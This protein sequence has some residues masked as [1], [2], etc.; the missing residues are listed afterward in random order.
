MLA[1]EKGPPSHLKT[2]PNDKTRDN[3]AHLTFQT[4]RSFRYNKL[5]NFAA[6]Y[7]I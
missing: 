2:K 5:K 1:I 7:F 4:C 3:D 6:L